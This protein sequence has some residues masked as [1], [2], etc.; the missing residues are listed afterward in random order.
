MSG[1]FDSFE[2]G[3]SQY[4][5]WLDTGRILGSHFCDVT[6]GGYV[7]VSLSSAFGGYFATA[8]SGV[9][10]RALRYFLDEVSAKCYVADSIADDLLYIIH[11]EGGVSYEYEIWHIVED[12]PETVFSDCY[13][14][15]LFKLSADS[16]NVVTMHLQDFQRLRSAG[17]VKVPDYLAPE[18]SRYSLIG[19]NFDSEFAVFGCDD[20]I[21]R[22]GSLCDLLRHI[23]DFF[24]ED[25]CGLYSVLR[26]TR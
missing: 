3:L 2:V 16:L 25:W 24:G 18:D 11:D 20:D 23:D 14:F 19:L 12:S 10:P 26:L 8:T 15:D 5:G 7:V 13:D 21:S 22:L 4:R 17:E 6:C 1:Y 9:I